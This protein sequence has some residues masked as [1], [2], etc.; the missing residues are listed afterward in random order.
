L[1]RLDRAVH[2]HNVL[3]FIVCECE[4]LV[5]AFAVFG[6]LLLC[7]LERLR[8]E[9]VRLH[10]ADWEVQ[11]VLSD[12]RGAE[13]IVFGLVRHTVFKFAHR[14]QNSGSICL[15]VIALLAHSKFNCEPVDCCES[16]DVL[17]AGTEGSESDFLTEVGEVMM[18]KHGSVA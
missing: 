11:M 18:G 1:A 10:R 16:L 5:D 12:F 4:R 17:L 7:V 3:I 9:V 8:H 2:L 6:N 15:E 14:A 13:R